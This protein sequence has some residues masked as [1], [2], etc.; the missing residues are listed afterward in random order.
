MLFGIEQNVFQSPFS[1]LVSIILSL[2]VIKIGTF[3]QKI[4][5]KILKIDLSNF[6][7]FFSPIIG[8]YFLLFPLYLSLIFE[9]Y[10][11]LLIKLFSYCLF[12]LGI[13]QF[14]KIIKK[15]LKI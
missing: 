7:I 3:F 4:I 13:F 6:N 1:L 9:I 12:I 14:F 5:L 15:K 10:A 8:V 2:G 11:I